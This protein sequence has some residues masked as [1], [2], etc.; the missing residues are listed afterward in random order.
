MSLLVGI[1]LGQRRIH[2]VCLDDALALSDAWVVDADDVD[3]LSLMVGGARVI[4]IDSPEALS[5]APHHDDESLSPKFRDARCAEIALGRDRGIWV[6]WVT[7]TTEAASPGWMH[8]GFQVFSIARRSAGRVIEVFPHAGFR[9][10]AG[11][12]VPSKL[13]AAGSLARSELLARAGVTIKGLEMW[14][15]DGLDAC[16]AAVIARQADRGVAEPVSCDHDGSR[17]WLPAQP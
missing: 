14:S 17:I 16:L 7:P 13:T 3:G 4:A 10:L 1:D 6:P 8:V 9:T 11:A 2:V 15:H 12:R 5:T